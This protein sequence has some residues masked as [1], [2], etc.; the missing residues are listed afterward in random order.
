MDAYTNETE[1]S[2]EYAQSA[3]DEEEEK[4]VETPC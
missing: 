3:I 1:E 2:G 4:V